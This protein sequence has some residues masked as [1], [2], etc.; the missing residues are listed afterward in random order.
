MTCP[1]VLNAA[2]IK[3]VSKKLD[4]AKVVHLMHQRTLSRIIFLWPLPFSV[5]AK[6]L[7]YGDQRYRK[8]YLDLLREGEPVGPTHIVFGGLILGGALWATVGGLGRRG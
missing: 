4:R 8:A 6:R 3:T 7:L 1:Y 2:V 5:D